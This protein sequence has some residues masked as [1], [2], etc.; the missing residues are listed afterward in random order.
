MLVLSQLG[1][2]ITKRLTYKLN[3]KLHLPLKTPVTTVSAWP[4]QPSVSSMSRK[5]SKFWETFKGSQ[6]TDRSF[7]SY[8]IKAS[9]APNK[10]SILTWSMYFLAAYQVMV[11]AFLAQ[12]STLTTLVLICVSTTS[13]RQLSSRLQIRWEETILR[14]PC[15]NL[16]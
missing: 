6:K 9:Y 12:W 7:N 16:G 8:W 4:N 3:S 13:L 2:P 10:R 5:N 1:R 11:S 15:V 14:R